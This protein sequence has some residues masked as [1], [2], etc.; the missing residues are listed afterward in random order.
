LNEKPVNRV[1]FYGFLKISVLEEE[2]R[3]PVS[4]ISRK[5]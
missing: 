3:H 2:N 4:R 1:K 5:L